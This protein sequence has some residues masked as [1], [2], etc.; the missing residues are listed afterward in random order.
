MIR[1]HYPKQDFIMILNGFLGSLEQIVTRFETSLPE[2]KKL[3]V[4]QYQLQ[5]ITAKQAAQAGQ[6]QL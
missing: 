4:E 6:A 5:T 1:T 3:D 2:L